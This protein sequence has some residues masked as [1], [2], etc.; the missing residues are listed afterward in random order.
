M[1]S[2]ERL[3][4]TLNHQPTD[5]V[6]LDLGAT[7]QTGISASTLYRLRKSLGLEEHRIKIIEPGQLLG[8]VEEDLSL[9]LRPESPLTLIWMRRIFGLWRILRKTLAL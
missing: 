9:T 6:V 3:L 2:R 1:T 5:R 8:E 4:A 7:S